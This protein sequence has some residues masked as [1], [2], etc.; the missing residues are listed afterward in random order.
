MPG[1]ELA[2][3]AQSVLRSSERKAKD[4]ADRIAY[5]SAESGKLDQ[6]LDSALAQWQAGLSKTRATSGQMQTLASTARPPLLPLAHAG[7]RMP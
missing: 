5:E 3:L 2:V 7:W 1:S 4:V 6:R